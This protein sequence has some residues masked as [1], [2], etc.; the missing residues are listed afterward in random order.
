M[1][2]PASMPRRTPAGPAAA[3][4]LFT[5]T[6]FA[7]AQD[8]LPQPVPA[9]ALRAA[10]DMVEPIAPGGNAPNGESLGIW[11]GGRNYKVRFD[12]GMTYYP[13]VGAELP[14]QPFAWR[15]T[16]VRAGA[17]ELLTGSAVPEPTCGPTRCD[18]DF[19]S[20][21]ERYDLQVGGLEQSF[22]IQERP[23]AGDLVICGSVTSPL[24][25]AP[26]G[27]EHGALSLR[28]AD[29]RAI[30]E[31]GVAVA[32]DAAG[33]RTPI[34]TA[35]D[36]KAITLRVPADV[37]AGATFPLVIDPLL[38][39]VFLESGGAISDVDVLYETVTD[40]L[41]DAGTWIVYSRIAAAGDHDIFAKRCGSHF[42]GTLLPT[43]QEISNWDSTGGQL[44]I[45]P[46]AQRVLIAHEIDGG[47]VTT[48]AVEEHWT[49]DLALR[50]GF[51]IPFFVNNTCQWR[52]DLGGRVGPSGNQIMAVWQHE[53]VTPFANT[54]T[55]TVYAAV[56]DATTTPLSLSVAPFRVH[57]AANVDQERPVCNQSSAGNNWVVAYQT[58]NGNVVNDDW[59]VLTFGVDASGV[60]TAGSVGTDQ[61]PDPLTHSVAPQIAGGNGRFLLTYTTRTFQ[62]QNP[63][64]ASALGNELWAQRIDWDI[65][66]GTITKPYPA[67]LLHGS[68][69]NDL[70]AEGCAFDDTSKSHWCAAAIDQASNQWRLLKLGYTGNVVESLTYNPAAGNTMTDVAVT[71]DG[72]L[73]HFP[74][75]LGAD[76]ATPAG[77]LNGNAVAYVTVPPPATIGFACG[78]GVWT[79]LD[80]T[81]NRQQIGSQAMPL[82]LTGAPIDTLSFLMI[83]TSQIN[84]PADVF[85]APGC[86]I[87]PDL[88]PTLL[89]IVTA[90]IVGGDSLLTLDLPEYLTPMTLY[91]QWGYLVPGANDLGIQASE[92]LSIQVNR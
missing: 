65:A 61:G 22:V 38:T 31:Y 60:V 20:F 43:Y 80:A 76:T 67:V 5:L 15:T 1:S 6:G 27:A 53:D 17:T 37:V 90:P 81:G 85:G 39:N 66:A 69:G 57:A 86:V 84:V 30:V 44:A 14:H 13:H 42:A 82:R 28:L 77:R 2:A 74:F 91:L 25:L 54:A 51:D 9:D 73:R 89:G 75:V 70:R 45:A 29:G 19:G 11:G 49:F 26:H 46:G 34:T 33:V 56:I 72:A 12:G 3:A 63:K 58:N 55:S 40:P 83:A 52:P 16:S 87:V 48:V 71:F 59:D 88:G 36:G 64:P 35:T 32:I 18:Y 8:P 41:S 21:V 62:L 50:T 92:G 68:A 7:A 23:N 78:S 10:C 4:A 47:G 79:G 24:Q